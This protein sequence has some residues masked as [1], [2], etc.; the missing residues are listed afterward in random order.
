MTPMMQKNVLVCMS[1]HSPTRLRLRGDAILD[2]YLRKCLFLL[3]HRSKQPDTSS[4]LPCLQHVMG[5]DNVRTD[6]L[7]AGHAKPR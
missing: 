5:W 7:R 2:Y 1:H 4:P 3:H 6:V